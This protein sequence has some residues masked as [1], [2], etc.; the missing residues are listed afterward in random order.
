MPEQQ[1]MTETMKIFE[2][3]Q[4]FNRLANRVYRHETRVMVEKSGIP[5]AGIVSAEDL[6]RLDRLDRERAERFKILEEFG[7]AFKDV[8]ADELEREVARAL[9]AVRAARQ[10]PQAPVLGATA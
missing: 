3:K 5:V 4:Q 7:E 6:R 10:A 9:A 1:P 8:P 2:V